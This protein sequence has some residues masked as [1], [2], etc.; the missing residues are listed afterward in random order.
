MLA[1]IWLLRFSHNDNETIENSMKNC[2]TSANFRPNQ[3]C[4]KKL[5]SIPDYRLECAK[6]SSHT[7][8]PLKSSGVVESAKFVSAYT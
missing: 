2:P 3:K 1:I 4:S 6:K 8:V 7:S 5:Y